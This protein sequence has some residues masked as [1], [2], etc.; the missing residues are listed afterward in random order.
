MYTAILHA[1]DLSEN[2]Y[3]M[4]EQAAEIAKRL[5]AK[6]YLIHVVETPDTMVL[7]QGLGFT[8]IEKPNALLEDANLVMS[9]L[10]EAFNLAKNHLFVEF[11]SAKQI[12]LQKAEELNC[13]MIIVGHHSPQNIPVTLGS[14]AHSVVDQA[15]CDVLTL[16]E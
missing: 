12:I 13:Q 7:A 15:P 1:T 14:T 3:K 11:G 5:N 10:G 2:H 6:L 16:R 4:C 9:I 8:E